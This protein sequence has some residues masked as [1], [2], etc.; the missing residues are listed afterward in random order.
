RPLA[1]ERHRAPLAVPFAPVK[2]RVPFLG[3]AECPALGE[4]ERRR[5]V[6]AIAHEFEPLFIRDQGARNFY[7][8]NQLAM[9]RALVIEYK[10]GAVVADG[11][12][13]VRDFDKTIAPLLAARHLPVLIV[14]GRG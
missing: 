3:F 11:V 5:R 8:M 10:T 12:H 2:R 1:T 7:R 6:A 14:S 13:A 4:P 9:R